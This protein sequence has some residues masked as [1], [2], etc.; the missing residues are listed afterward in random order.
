M[1]SQL[2]KKISV[3]YRSLKFVTTA[4]VAMMVKE[5]SICETSVSFYAPTQP[6][7]AEDNHL[8]LFLLLSFYFLLFLYLFVI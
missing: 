2:A 8:L 6:D 5:I 4:V 1:E 3:F 7:V